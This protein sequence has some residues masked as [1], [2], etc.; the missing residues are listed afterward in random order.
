MNQTP[1]YKRRDAEG[2]ELF[3]R[4]GLSIIV[5]RA[6]VIRIEV[7]MMNLSKYENGEIIQKK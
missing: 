2:V 6:S 3:N 5:N 1:L 7:E 4:L